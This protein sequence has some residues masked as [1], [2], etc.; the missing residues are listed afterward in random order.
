[1]NKKLLILF[2]IVAIVII[3][4]VIIIIFQNIGDRSENNNKLITP[5]PIQS[6]QG[7][8]LKENVPYNNLAKE[9]VIDNMQNR[10]ELSDRGKSS[11]QN[12]LNRLNNMSG[13]AYETIS[14]RLE[15]IQSPDIFMAEI[16][17]SDINKAK[18]EAADYL[19]SEGFSQNDV[20]ILP[21]VFYLNAAIALE[22]RET[23]IEFSPLPLD[24]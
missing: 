12:I 2:G 16:K 3:I 20:C 15:Y 19:I 7:K 9:K 23:G 22:I 18:K 6:F 14:F 4:S 1:M 8:T 21:L 17:T 10:Q 5:T 13:V 11:R 24:C